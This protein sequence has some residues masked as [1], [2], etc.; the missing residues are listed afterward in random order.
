MLQHLQQPAPCR[1]GGAQPG[2]AAD[3]GERATEAR[4]CRAQGEDQPYSEGNLFLMWTSDTRH[5]GWDPN[6]IQSH[7]F[8]VG[9]NDIRHILWK[10][11]KRAHY[12]S[13]INIQ[14][15]RSES[16]APSQ[17]PV[18]ETQPQFT[19]VSVTSIPLICMAQMRSAAATFHTKETQIEVIACYCVYTLASL[20][21][22]PGRGLLC[23]CVCF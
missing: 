13:R 18:G 15:M 3:D 6:A 22:W 5:S 14:G 12:K 11:R 7:T 9:C 2:G 10:W 23:V 8:I 17:P 4:A 19:V 16:Q 21:S 20:C 1:L